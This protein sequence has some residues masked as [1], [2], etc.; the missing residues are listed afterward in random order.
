MVAII[1]TL[2]VLLIVKEILWT[3]KEIQLIDR[4]LPP[5]ESPPKTNRFFK[6]ILERIKGKDKIRKSSM[7]KQEDE[8]KEVF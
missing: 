2:A 3:I 4:A 5:K 1:I 6:K 7:P 8:D